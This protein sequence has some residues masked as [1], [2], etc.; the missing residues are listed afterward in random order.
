MAQAKLCPNCGAEQPANSPEG[1][2]PRCLM[3]NALGEPTPAPTELSTDASKDT[4]EWTPDP[5]DVTRTAQG[6]QIDR[7]LPN[8]TTIRYFGDYELQDILGRG[9]MGVV[10]KALQVSLNRPVALK[11]IKAGVLA[12]EAELKRFQN[13]AEAVALLDHAGVV[14]VYEVGEHEGQRYFSMKLVEG[15]NLSQ[16][17]ASFKNNPRAAANLL[18]ETAE[19]VHHA[20]MRGILHRDLKPANI[21][22]D[23]EGHPH[24]TDFGL[25]RRVEGHVEMTQS[26]AV[27]GTPAYMSPEQASGRRGS[28]T[29]A[30]DVYGLGAI[31]YALL[32]GKAP[33][34]GDS[35]VDT[36]DA[37][38]NRLPE[39]PKNFNSNVPHDLE[40]ICLKCLD[41]DPRKRYASAHDIAVDLTNWLESRP[42]AA[43]RVG[44]A[45]R[46][47]LWC[48]RKPAVAGLAAA[49]VLAAV[50]GTVA[51]IAVQSRANRD[52]Q[53]SNKLLGKQRRRAEDNETQAI[54]AVK[55]FRDAVA[56][57]PTLKNSPALEDLRKR[58]LKE[59]LGFFKSLR[60]R[61]QADHDAQPKSLE[62]LAQ[63]GLDLGGLNNEIGDKEDAL[64][65]CR[66]ALVIWEK[67][68]R[69]NPSDAEL[70][71]DLAVCHN[72][73]GGLER[74]IGRPA[75]AIAEHE[76]SR[77]IWERL[78]KENP[79]EAKYQNKLAGCCLNLGGL[80]SDTGKPTEAL[81]NLEK[82]RAIW[83]RL[84][85]A[86]PSAVD[87]QSDLAK[88]YNN[89]ATIQNATGKPDAAMSSLEQFR[90]IQRT[91]R[92]IIPPFP[93]I[94]A[95]SHSVSTTL[96]ISS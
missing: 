13:E 55:K 49:V 15:G 91:W 48:K 37:V 26:G 41:K 40:T 47:W 21:L 74:E 90:D 39:P 57:E 72:N 11:M 71:N 69:E 84:T 16:Q 44:P 59:P 78:A 38:R 64:H 31:L 88:C 1:L 76:K 83:E 23:A 25:A 5:S 45:E 62:R 43:R 63:A 66:E 87:V 17:L 8:N 22:I 58:L 68:A 77:A 96:A 2:C 36:L 32:T 46:A 53:A 70:Q 42:I 85:R 52:L 93:N 92:K 29:T 89:I 60:D 73:I 18:V 80:Q 27:L 7:K 82:A 9:G 67:L 4:G 56:N 51:V 14:P 10:Y 30:T 75:Q 61:L 6:L 94:S 24:V 50:G 28:I 81:A 33:F 35:V 79:S 86:D 19:A 20:H 12:D 54:E 65:D 34:G 3:M 95:T